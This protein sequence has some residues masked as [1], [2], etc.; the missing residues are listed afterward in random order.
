MHRFGI[1]EMDMDISDGYRGRSHRVDFESIVKAK[2]VGR[3]AWCVS[4]GGHDAAMILLR[5]AAL[6]VGGVACNGGGSVIDLR[7]ARLAKP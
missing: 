3:G 2:S 6:G 7:V 5:G 4:R 1:A